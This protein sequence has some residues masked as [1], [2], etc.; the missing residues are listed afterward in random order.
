[1]SSHNGSGRYLLDEGFPTRSRKVVGSNPTSGSKTAGQSMCMVILSI[2]LLA[3]LIIL[4]ART[5]TRGGPPPLRHVGVRLPD[6]EPVDGPPWSAHDKRNSGRRTIQRALRTGR[7]FARIRENQVAAAPP[8][9][10]STRSI[11]I[12]AGEPTSLAVDG[13]TGAQAHWLP[14]RRDLDE[15]RIR[16]RYAVDRGPG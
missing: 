14:H 5:W 2:A 7:A 1:M 15:L 3:S 9:P 4:C 11:L 10:H 13:G 8:F 16:C 6:S 12:L